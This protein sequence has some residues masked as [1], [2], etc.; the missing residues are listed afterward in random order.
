MR[1]ST[2]SRPEAQEVPVANT[3]ELRRLRRDVASLRDALRTA[4]AWDSGFIPKQFR[5]KLDR[6]LA[7][8]QKKGTGGS[9]G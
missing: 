2:A 1:T 6:V 4:L 3:P 7:R 8:A 5:V 9:R